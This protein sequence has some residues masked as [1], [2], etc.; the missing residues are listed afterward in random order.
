M[1]T[2]WPFFI[3]APGLGFVLM[4]LLGPK[5]QGLLIPGGILL[6]VGAFF[7]FGRTNL[8]YLWPFLL[9]AAGV[10]VL[11]SGLGRKR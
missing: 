3:L 10:S 9:I 6:A 2:L 1:R 7:L 8:D 5:E 4:Y 11:V